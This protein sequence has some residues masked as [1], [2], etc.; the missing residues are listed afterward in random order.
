MESIVIRMN[1]FQFDL[2]SNFVYNNSKVMSA[3]S[4][5]LTDK[6]LKSWLC[7]F[8]CVINGQCLILGYDNIDSTRQ[9]Y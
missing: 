7:N 4:L 8:F 9:A 1:E 3:H 6:I 2:K 5:F